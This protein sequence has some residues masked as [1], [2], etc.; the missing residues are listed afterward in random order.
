MFE[1]SL[2]KDMY[3]TVCEGLQLSYGIYIKKIIHA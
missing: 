1:K 3:E 2:I